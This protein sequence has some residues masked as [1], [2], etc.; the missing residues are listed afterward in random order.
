MTDNSVGPQV[1]T[2]SSWS[3][4]R[5]CQK[6]YFW[7]YI[8]Q[9]V[10]L[11]TEPALV[12]GALMHRALRVWH[13]TQDE[14]KVFDLI[15]REQPREDDR[16]RRDW[17]LAM[18]MMA[19]YAA[20]YAKESFKVVFL[21]KTFRGE[22]LNPDTGFPSK[23]F[24]LA[25][26][27]DGLVERNGEL[28]LLE[29]KTASS[30]DSGYL[31][32]LWTDFQVSLY[33]GYVQK[34]VQKPIAGVLYNILAKP[35]LRQ[36]EA[37]KTRKVAETDQEFQLR[38]FEKLQEPS[39]FHREELLIPVEQI[40]QIHAELWR[41]TQI[42]LEARRSGIWSQNTSFCFHWNKACP[43]F[44]LC[45]SGGNPLVKENQYRIEPPHKELEDE[46][47]ETF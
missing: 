27:Y 33:K 12:F 46:A 43:Y 45:R 26:R 21:E 15:N 44:P 11:T 9:I 23:T 24:F 3:T 4:F 40:R 31:E 19:A 6:K 10:P 38:L 34:E 1:S 36:Y 30:I 39:M 20:H 37:G 8:E 35:A 22:I 29:H 5:N 42:Y 14:K 2:Y 13:E 17:N 7:R 32:R 25:G 41:L 16:G 18:A 28:W 47:E